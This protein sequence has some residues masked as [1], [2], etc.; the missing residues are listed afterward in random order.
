MPWTSATAFAYNASSPLPRRISPAA[1]KTAGRKESIVLVEIDHRV[2]TPPSL[3]IFDRRETPSGD[4]IY[5][6]DLRI[7]QPNVT[8]LPPAVVHSFEHFLI[9]HFRAEAPDEVVSAAPMG[10]QTGFYIT[11]VGM[12]DYDAMEELLA[13]CLVAVGEATEVPLANPSQCGWA[14]NHTLSGAQEL[15]AWLL[16]RRLE[17]R[18]P[19]P[20]E[21][22]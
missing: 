4:W 15:A 19:A 17:W 5:L 8:H 3:R 20:V 22:G 14:E 10:C 21:G 12:D 18:H 1:D 9:T 13:D 7:A 16:R 11:T 2:M 6:W